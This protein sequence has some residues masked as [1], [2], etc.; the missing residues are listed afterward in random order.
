MLAMRRLR[1]LFA[2]AA[3]LIG[4]VTWVAAQAIP[5]DREPSLEEMA[6]GRDLRSYDNGS[7]LQKERLDTAQLTV[8]RAFI[9][10]H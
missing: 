10:K 3:V 7:D 6:Q 9:W 2:L 8:L 4:S 5:L 1:H